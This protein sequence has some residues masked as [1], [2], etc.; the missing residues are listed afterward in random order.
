MNDLPRL[1]PEQEAIVR[2]WLPQAELITDLSWELMGTA[3]LHLRTPDGDRIVKAGGPTN[4][5]IGRERNAHL[6]F[7]GPWLAQ[8]RAARMFRSDIDTNMLLLDYLPG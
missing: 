6:E 5:H 7:T 1:T 3:V 2:E 8:G 4:H